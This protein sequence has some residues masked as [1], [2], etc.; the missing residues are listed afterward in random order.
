[1]INCDIQQLIIWQ[2]DFRRPL[3]RA[4]PLLF[5]SIPVMNL[6]QV[7]YACY[8]AHAVVW[9]SDRIYRPLC[10]R[11]T[12]VAR[13]GAVNERFR[14]QRICGQYVMLSVYAANRHCIPL[15]TRFCLKEQHFVYSMTYIFDFWQ[16]YLFGA[17]KKENRVNAL[18]E[19]WCFRDL[20]EN[21]SSFKVRQLPKH[22]S[23]HALCNEALTK[24][25]ID[26]TIFKKKKVQVS[27]IK[28]LI[29]N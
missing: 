2:Q 1:M 27:P 9:Y 7:I 13:K 17:G 26:S 5:P 3:P 10:R 6:L 4:H 23:T 8:T 11:K 18:I 22:S 29:L 12:G 25:T 19:V 15:L 16:H 14:P 20:F 24:I 21:I 28:Y